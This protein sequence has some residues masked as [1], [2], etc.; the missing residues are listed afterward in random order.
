VPT[1]LYSASASLMSFPNDVLPALT[2]LN[3]NLV[4][5]CVY[6]LWFVRWPPNPP[7]TTSRGRRCWFWGCFVGVKNKRPLAQLFLNA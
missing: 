4:W 1:V 7:R 3:S 2:P 6:A 5:C